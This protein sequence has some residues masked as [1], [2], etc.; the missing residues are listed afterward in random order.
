MKD[1]INKFRQHN[2]QRPANFEGGI[3]EYNCLLHCFHMA[4][5]ERCIHTPNYLM[6]KWEAEIVGVIEYSDYWKDRLVFDLW[7]NSVQHKEVLLS[8]NS[9]T[10]KYF[11]NNYNVW[12][13]VR[14]RY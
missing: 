3:D 6:G 8:S 7:G 5:N 10:Y 2:N 4:T 1:V 11:I 9:F 12:A 14:G 13:V